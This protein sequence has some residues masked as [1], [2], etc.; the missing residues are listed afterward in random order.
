MGTELALHHPIRRRGPLVES[1]RIW[2]T[3][4]AVGSRN[5]YSLDYVLWVECT[6]VCTRVISTFHF[7]YH[8]SCATGF[9]FV[10]IWELRRTHCLVQGS[11]NTYRRLPFSVFRTC[12]WLPGIPKTPL[13]GISVFSTIRLRYVILLNEECISFPY[14]IILV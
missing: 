12:G 2:R 8:P 13:V 11:G 9:Y 10:S 14:G 4:K 6:V 3:R 5:F 1:R 7:L